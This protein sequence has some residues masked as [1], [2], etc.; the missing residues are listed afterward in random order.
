MG[1]ALGLGEG[2]GVGEG[3]GDLWGCHGGRGWRELGGS[4]RLQLTIGSVMKGVVLG[5][6]GM[7]RI[8][9]ELLEWLGV[10]VRWASSQG[11]RSRWELSWGWWFALAGQVPEWGKSQWSKAAT[12]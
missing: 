4:S 10:V 1:G 5:G 11:V 7:H 12:S 9:P 3:R 6:V 2:V 8:S